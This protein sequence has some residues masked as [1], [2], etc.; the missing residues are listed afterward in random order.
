MKFEELLAALAE[1]TTNGPTD[2]SEQP[3]A[4][5]FGSACFASGPACFTSA[6]DA[7]LDAEPF[8]GL[9]YFAR[10][11]TTTGFP[12]W[13]TAFAGCFTRDCPRCFPAERGFSLTA[14]CL[15]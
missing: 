12:A 8:L 3:T 6:Q 14:C 1:H 2:A 10:E 7:T 9:G 5:L 13:R 15:V 11:T 4:A